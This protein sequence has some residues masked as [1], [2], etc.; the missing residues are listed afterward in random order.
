MRELADSIIVNIFPRRIADKI[1]RQLT[2]RNSIRSIT[3][4]VEMLAHEVKNPLSGIRGAAQ[5]IEQDAE[6]EDR[7]LTR[8][9]CDE[10]DRICALLD[11]I[12]VFSDHRPIK[13]SPVNLHQVLERVRDISVTGF[14][15]NYS[16]IE[17]Y[18]PSLP[19]ADGNFDQLVQ[20]FLNLFKNAVEAT[21][22]IGGQ[23]SITTSYLHGIRL[24]VPGLSSG[25]QLPLMIAVQDNGEGISEDLQNYL[26]EPFVTSKAKGSGLGLA[27]TA[28]IVEAH[29]GVIE[30]ESQ[31]GRTIFRV[32][33]PKEPKE[34]KV[35]RCL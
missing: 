15:K 26:F 4:M 12:E 28:K 32:L 30:F 31:P 5:L 22:K 2:H 20:V 10:T 21:P 1:D 7:H 11:R 13:R 25:S 17:N 23:I 29:G 19:L 6:P 34:G 24:A 9:I 16:I 18:D 8:L 35:K 27:L 14:A 3:A 33:L